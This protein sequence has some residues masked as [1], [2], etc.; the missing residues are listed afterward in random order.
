MNCLQNK[1]I[2]PYW[3]NTGN[4]YILELEFMK[5]SKNSTDFKNFEHFIKVGYYESKNILNTFIT[6]E[7]IYDDYTNNFWSLLFLCGYITPERNKINQTI[8]YRIPNKEVEY[9]FGNLFLKQWAKLK[10]PEVKNIE[11][12]FINYDKYLDDPK[13]LETFFKEEFLNKM[14]EGE[15]KEPDFQMLFGGFGLL[16]RILGYCDYNVSAEA[17]VPTTLGKIDNFLTSKKEVVYLHEFKVIENSMKKDVI[18]DD[19]LW[20]IYGQRYMFEP[21]SLYRNHSHN[22]NWTKIVTRAIVFYQ[23]NLNHQWS[24]MI[25]EFRHSINIAKELDEKFNK[26]EFR[27]ELNDKKSSTNR[28]ENR[29]LFLTQNNVQSIEEFLLKYSQASEKNEPSDD[30]RNSKKRKLEEEKDQFEKKIH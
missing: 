21:L 13:S 26:F 24:V 25:K 2:K 19:A 1:T 27:E 10:F 28:V 3:I 12:L 4:P 23:D 8:K 30:E 15:K 9:Q 29:N 5:M 7:S 16:A 18:A 17:I 22:K 20:Q 6:I 14:K 11:S